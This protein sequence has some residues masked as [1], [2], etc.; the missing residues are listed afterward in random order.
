MLEQQG[1]VAA[2]HPSSFVCACA[3]K[4]LCDGAAAAPSLF[5]Y[6]RAARLSR[7]QDAKSDF[8]SSPLVR[9]PFQCEGYKKKAK[10]RCKSWSLVFLHATSFSPSPKV[11]E[12]AFPPVCFALSL[13]ACL[14]A[15][16]P[17]SGSVRNILID[18]TTVL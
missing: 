18:I 1:I 9:N 6:V 8:F 3:L 16:K 10:Q 12:M 15:R 2:P 17:S 4:M 5:S 7:R 11:L 13:L 14:L